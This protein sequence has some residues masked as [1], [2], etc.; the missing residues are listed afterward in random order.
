MQPVERD[1]EPARRSL[2][3]VAR[4]A[5]D[6]QRPR[7]REGADEREQL[8]D[9]ALLALGPVDPDRDRGRAQKSAKQ[10]SRSR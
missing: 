8:G 6:E 2:R 4:G 5:R 10:S 7:R 3:R 9:R 1:G